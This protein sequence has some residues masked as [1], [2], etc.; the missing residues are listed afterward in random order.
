MTLQTIDQAALG[1]DFEGYQ[2]GSDVSLILERVERAGVGPRLHRHPY[3]ETFV[4]RSGSALFT[5]GDKKIEAVGGQILV[6][7]ALVPHMF[8]TLTDDV[9]EAIHIHANDRFVTEWLE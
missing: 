5:V 2:F 8:R 9:Y 6:V 3:S 7:P 1:G 4:I